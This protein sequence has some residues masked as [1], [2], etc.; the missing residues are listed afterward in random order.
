M[1]LTTQ[2]D[3]KLA[4]FEFTD[5]IPDTYVDNI[6]MLLLEISKYKANTK[7]KRTLMHEVR[8]LMEQHGYISFAAQSQNYFLSRV[9]TSYLYDVPNTK[10]GKLRVFRGK[11]IRVV[12]I[13]SGKTF[14]RQYMAGIV[15]EEQ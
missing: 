4:K 3:K 10:R 6:G 11:R 2:K 9:G 1:P 8:D 7:S 13:G 5:T 14:R 15:L 12:C